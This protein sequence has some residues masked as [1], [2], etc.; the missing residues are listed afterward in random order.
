M[1]DRRSRVLTLLVNQAE[2]YQLYLRGLIN[3]TM[4]EPYQLCLRGLGNGSTASTAALDLQAL[5]TR[6]VSLLGPRQN[7][8]QSKSKIY[9]EVY[10]KAII[11]L[12]LSLQ[13]AR[14]VQLMI[15]SPRTPLLWTSLIGAS[16]VFKCQESTTLLPT[17]TTVLH[18]SVCLGSSYISPTRVDCFF[19]GN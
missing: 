3:G 12:G 1:Q 8:G 2:P 19:Q 10:R 7:R 9:Q 13:V 5:K 11:A 15:E 17:R 18:C 6:E 16:Q 4:A 14:G